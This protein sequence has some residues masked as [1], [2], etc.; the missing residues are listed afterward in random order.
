MDAKALNRMLE[1]RV[2]DLA[3]RPL[4]RNREEHAQRVAA[5]RDELLRCLGIYPLPPRTDLKSEVT[6]TIQ[7]ERYRIDKLRYESRPGELVTAHLYLPEGEGPFPVILNPHG[8]WQYKKCEPVVQARGISLALQGFAA[9]VIDSPG[10]S[11]DDN[12]QNERKAMGPHDDWFLQMGS[13]VTGVYVWDLMRGL[14]YLETRPEIDSKRVGVTGASGGGLTS[15]YAFAVDTRIGAAVPVAYPA[16]YEDMPFNGCLCNHV[17]GALLLGDRS[18][19]LA[20]RAPAPVMVI[21][22]MIDE[23]FPAEGT[24][25]TYS[26]LQSIYKLYREQAKVRMELV[27]GGHDYSRRMREAMIAFFREHLMGE[28]PK[29]YV[30][31]A[32]PLTDGGLVPYPSGTV[33]PDDPGLLVTRWDQRQTTTFRELLHTS[34]INPYPKE[35]SAEHRLVRWGKYGKLPL[36]QAG[37][38]L[39]L[40]DE[41]N[42]DAG[43]ITLPIEHLDERSCIYIGLSPAEFFAQVLHLLC[44]GGPE[45]WESVGAHGDILTSMIASMKTLAGKPKE[46]EQPTEVVATGPVASMTAKHLKLLRP[47]LTVSI[48]HDFKSWDDV[49]ASGVRQIAMPKARYLAWPF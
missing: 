23:E 9:L 48:S 10:V 47:E 16:S 6:G 13:P 8:H 7:R 34:L 24:K 26:K 49:L 22:A 38:A 17:P 3:A 44:P 11:W 4:P 18:D 42:N 14:D 28:K 32:R 30:V 15:M 43:V 19:V 12:D 37:G 40:A 46:E 20:M 2:R 39:K 29:P 25:R 1:L 27:E 35:L 41:P 33:P 21:G 31:E 45:G 5:E 36:A